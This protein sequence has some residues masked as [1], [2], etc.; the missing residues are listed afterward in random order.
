LLRLS[1]LKFPDVSKKNPKKALQQL[2]KTTLLPLLERI[3]E[4]VEKQSDD[5]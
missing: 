4:A 2:L 5:F 1:E 3:E